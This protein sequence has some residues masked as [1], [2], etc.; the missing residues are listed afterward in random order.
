MTAHLVVSFFRLG[1]DANA[2]VMWRIGWLLNGGALGWIRWDL[3]AIGDVTCNA[4]SS[5]YAYMV[6][7]WRRGRRTPEL[8]RRPEDLGPTVVSWLLED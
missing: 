1:L 8:A 7:T 6:G 2:G 4:S 5:G 3:G